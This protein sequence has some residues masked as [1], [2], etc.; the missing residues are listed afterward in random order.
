MEIWGWPLGSASARFFFGDAASLVHSAD[1]WVVY[2]SY[3]VFICV[4]LVL[5]PQFVVVCLGDASIGGLGF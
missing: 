3:G 4:E 1:E 5:I 2:L